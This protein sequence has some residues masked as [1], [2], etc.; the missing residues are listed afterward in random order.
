MGD[1]LEWWQKHLQSGVF[2]PFLYLFAPSS[3]YMPSCVLIHP[4]IQFWP[5][6][7][8]LR[9]FRRLREETLV[10]L[11]CYFFLLCIFL[12]KLYDTY[13]FVCI[14]TTYFYNDMVF[15]QKWVALAPFKTL[16]LYCVK[17]INT[18]LVNFK[19]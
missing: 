7:K 11:K 4:L 17:W 6:L 1:C 13:V 5:P 3:V 2:A 15:T 9:R 12:L 14:L 10:K 8:F 18:I 16:P 19:A